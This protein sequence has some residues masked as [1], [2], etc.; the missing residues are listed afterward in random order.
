MEADILVRKIPRGQYS[1]ARLKA[2]YIPFRQVF[3][4]IVYLPGSETGTAEENL[5]RWSADN[6]RLA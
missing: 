4:C 2:D 5:A 6:G 3:R 1:E